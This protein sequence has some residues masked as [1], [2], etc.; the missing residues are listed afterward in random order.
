MKEES[1]FRGTVAVLIVVAASIR[2]Q[3]PQSR[4]GQRGGRDFLPRSR[5]A[6]RDRAAIFWACVDALGRGLPDQPALDEVIEPGPSGFSALVGSGTR[7]G[8]IA[9]A[10]WVF[11]NIGKNTI[12]TVEIRE[13]HELLITGPYRWVRH[14]LYTAGIT[15]FA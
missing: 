10:V 13:E 4:R 14:P 15:F 12:P 6:N 11:R 9:S 2:L 7:S 3:P 1:V 5:F 8:V